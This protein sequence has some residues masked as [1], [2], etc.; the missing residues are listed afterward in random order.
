MGTWDPF[1]GERWVGVQFYVVEH[2]HGEAPL[3]PTGLLHS[4]GMIALVVKQDL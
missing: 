2:P 3:L 1:L 4:V